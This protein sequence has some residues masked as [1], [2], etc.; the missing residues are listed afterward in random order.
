MNQRLSTTPT[1]VLKRA[2]RSAAQALQRAVQ[3]QD[4]AQ[5]LQVYPAAVREPGT[6]TA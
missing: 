1:C 2:S 4:L 5:A 3:A 6:G